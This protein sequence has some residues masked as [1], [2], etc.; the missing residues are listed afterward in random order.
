MLSCCSWPQNMQ[1]CT[2][3][4]GIIPGIDAYVNGVKY[5][6]HLRS[7]G[8]RKVEQS[9]VGEFSLVEE[10]CRCWAPSISHP[11]CSKR[12]HNHCVSGTEQPILRV[13]DS[14]CTL[15]CFQTLHYLQLQMSAQ[16]NWGSRSLLQWKLALSQKKS[17]QLPLTQMMNLTPDLLCKLQI[18]NGRCIKT[19]TT[20]VSSHLFTYD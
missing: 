19:T 7:M 13:S 20:E 16:S 17:W 18:S 1:F 8:N 4:K 15:N 3:C 14:S 2:H 6:R 9:P 10:L 5:V 11:C 12:S